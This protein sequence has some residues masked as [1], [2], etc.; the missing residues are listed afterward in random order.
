[1]FGGV[2]E[3]LLNE[4]FPWNRDILEAVEPVQGPPP[5]IKN[6][7]VK[8]AIDEMKDGKAVSST[9]IVAE[10]MKASRDIGVNSIT[11]LIN[12]IMRETSIPDD[13]LRSVMVNIYK[14]KGVVLVQSNCRGL[15][16]LD[17]GMKVVES[18]M[19][20]LIRQC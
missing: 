18:V 11:K 20:K 1:M 7:W 19:D 13:W 5:E 12:T 16:L 9:G 15:K 10:I 14:G 6:E 17:H 3:R 4:E 2:T 8:K